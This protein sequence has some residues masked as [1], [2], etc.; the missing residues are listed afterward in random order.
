MAL[1]HK[2]VSYCILI[3]T[4]EKQINKKYW[5]SI[6]QYTYEKIGMEKQNEVRNYKTSLIAGKNTTAV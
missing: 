4:T 5:A 1:N 3:T 2:S 6:R